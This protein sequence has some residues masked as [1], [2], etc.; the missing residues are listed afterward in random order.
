MRATLASR[1]GMDQTTANAADVSCMTLRRRSANSLIDSPDDP[2]RRSREEVQEGRDERRRRHLVPGEGRRILR[3]A[4]PE[5]GGK[6]DHD[7]DP[8]DD[9]FPDER[10]RDD[11]R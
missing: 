6:D 4:W 5:R 10:P 8:H 9:A 11:R 7:L 2:R 1:S 3:A